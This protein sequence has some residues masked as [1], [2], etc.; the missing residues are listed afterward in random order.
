MRDVKFTFLQRFAAEDHVVDDSLAD[1]AIA[2][3]QR[4]K[5]IDPASP[6]FLY[7]APGATHTPHMAPREW[8]DKFRVS[9]T[10]GGIAIAR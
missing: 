7:V 3:M 1:H 10:W 6:L 4:S 2:W 8:L 9:S 5:A